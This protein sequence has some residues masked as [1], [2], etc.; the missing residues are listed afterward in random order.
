MAMAG[1]TDTKAQELGYE[2]VIGEAQAASK[3]PGTMPDA[4]PMRVKLVFDRRWGK[5]LGGCACCTQTVGEVANL[6]AA[7]IVNEMTMEQI[8]MFQMGTHP[9]LT[10]SPLVYQFTDAASDALHKIRNAC[11]ME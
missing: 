8:A 11:Q 2:V 5:V 9:C 7:A 6:I 4:K 1:L 3:H 10:A